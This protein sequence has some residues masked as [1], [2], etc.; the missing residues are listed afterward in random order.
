MAFPVEQLKL[1]L[2]KTI[3]PVY[4]IYGEE[5]QQVSEALDV[6][7]KTAAIAGYSERIRFFVK[8]VLTG[9]SCVPR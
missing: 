5:P 6:I 3:L 1:Q 2:N 8:A 4:L 9:Q 7:C